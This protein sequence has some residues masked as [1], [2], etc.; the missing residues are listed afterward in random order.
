MLPARASGKAKA[1]VYGFAGG[2]GLANFSLSVLDIFPRIQEVV[3]ATAFVL[4]LAAAGAAI[5]SLGDYGLALQRMGTSLKK[6]K[7]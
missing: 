6:K 5:W 2:L 7:K 4:F 1:W 3:A